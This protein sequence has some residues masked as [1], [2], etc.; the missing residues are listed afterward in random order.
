MN[1]VSQLLHMQVLPALLPCLLSGKTESAIP[2]MGQVGDMSYISY[3]HIYLSL[4]I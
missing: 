1:N 3:H 2:V 4:K